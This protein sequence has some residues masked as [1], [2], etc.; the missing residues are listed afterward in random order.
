MLAYA[1]G[2]VATEMSAPLIEVRGQTLAAV[3]ALNRIGKPEEIARTIVMLASDAASY[4]TGTTIDI[5]GGKFC[6]QDPAS[7]YS[8]CK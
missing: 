2:V 8:R 6:V 7:E 1:P 3:T 4:M 5:S